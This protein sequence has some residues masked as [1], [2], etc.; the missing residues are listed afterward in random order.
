MLLPITAIIFFVTLYYRR[1]RIQRENLEKIEEGHRRDML[2]ASI[3]SQEIVRRQI[4]GDLHDDIGTLLSATRMS[5]LQVSKHFADDKKRDHLLGQTELLLN[6]AIGNVRRISKELMPSALDE[7]GLIEALKDFS[8]KMTQNTGIDIQFVN[9]VGDKRFDAKVELSL[10]RT[11]QELV[12][13]SLKHAKASTILIELSQ[14]N[15]NLLLQMSDDGIGFDLAEVNQPDR[16]IGLKNMESRLS[17]LKGKI[18][19][20]VEKGRGSRFVIKVP[21]EYHRN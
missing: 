17:V 18:I 20:D 8:R 13:N 4:G 12:N 3:A 6:D 15:T 21:T 2:E 19:F 7:F 1:Q 14:E 5:L 10:Y 11:V 16:G 9:E